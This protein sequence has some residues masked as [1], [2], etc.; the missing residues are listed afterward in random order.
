MNQVQFRF[1][2]ELNNLLPEEMRKGWIE[3]SAEPGTTVGLKIS[4]LGIPLDEVDLILVNQQPE[5][6][7]YLLQEGDRVSVYP[8]FETFD[9]SSVSKLRDKPLRSPAFICDV[10]LGRLSKYLRM[11]G[12]DT[13]YSNQYTPDKMIE[14]S[15]HQHK[16]ILSRS[17][18]LITDKRVTHAF[19]ISSAN[20][21][22]QL[23]VLIDKLNLATLVNP[24][25]RC[26]HCNKLLENVEKQQI[27]D[28]LE[29]RTIKHF[30]EFFRCPVCDH[31]YWKGS[32]Y[33]HMQQFIQQIM[34]L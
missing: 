10:H 2:E 28:R 24:L 17:M 19:W 30:T 34:K 15:N 12:F 8:V 32:H 25:S 26:L 9:I 3:T 7:D 5:S 16:I 22:E 23:H 33:E 31:I 11:L 18:K 20:P 6:F 14:I 13:L 1:Y 4:S 27:I 29:E 21:T